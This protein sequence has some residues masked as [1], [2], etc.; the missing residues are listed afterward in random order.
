MAE[1]EM[2][3]LRAQIDAAVE[4]PSFDEIL[5]RGEK[6]RHA[7]VGMVL[8]AVLLIGGGAFALDRTIAEYRGSDPVD[9]T[10]DPQ[11]RTAEQIIEDPSSSYDTVK[12]LA[13]GREYA[14]WLDA[15]EKSPCQ[16]AVAWSDD[17]WATR[18]T[19]L[20]PAASDYVVDDDGLIVM[21][22][23]DPAYIVNPDGTSVEIQKPD[24]PAPLQDGE[25][26]VSQDVRSPAF[27]F[28]D[29]ETGESHRI[30]APPHMGIDDITQFET[31]ELRAIGHAPDESSMLAKSFDGGATWSKQPIP[32]PFVTGGFGQDETHIN[33]VESDG[34]RFVSSS[35][36][37]ATW[38]APQKLPFPIIDCST[39][40]SRR[41]LVHQQRCALDDVG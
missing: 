22:W 41:L 2:R 19:E 29:P 4:K 10:P 16:V 21:P 39:A 5:A 27:L 13:D 14:A 9:Q 3:A 15:C 26:V 18:T 37:G 1:L 25:I 28:V 34:L 12:R 32:A 8:A 17:G 24:A 35:D 20:L 30:M 31:G 23:D 36:A 38:S 6:R 33:L 11:P 40:V 7:R